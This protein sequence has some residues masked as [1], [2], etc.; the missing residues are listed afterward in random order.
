VPT[1]CR[2]LAVMTARDRASVDKAL[3]LDAAA[4]VSLFERCD[5]FRKPARF[6]QMVAA[7]ECAGS[8]SAPQRDRLAKALDA[9]R[10]VNAGEIAQRSSGQP[11]MIPALVRAARVHGVHEATGA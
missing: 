2:D 4:L 1:E 9:A 5:G 6:A 3:Q 11:Q 10:G 8:A 7:A